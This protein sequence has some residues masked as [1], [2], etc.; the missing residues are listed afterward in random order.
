MKYYLCRGYLG[1][2]IGTPLQKRIL[3]DDEGYAYLE[4]CFSNWL[5]LIFLK[6][7]K[8]EEAK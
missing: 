6:K 7:I 5:R 2:I 8:I 1:N 3:Y 4:V